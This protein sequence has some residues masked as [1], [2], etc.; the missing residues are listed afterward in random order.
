MSN[1]NEIK[2]ELKER[3][4]LDNLTKSNLSV[5]EYAW[6]K[7]QEQICAKCGRYVFLTIDHIIPKDIL[8]QFGVDVDMEFI[9]ENLQVNCRSCNYFKGNRMDFTIP[10]TKELLIKLISKI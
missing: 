2:K 7:D 9:E 6:L 4:K 1:L 3:K 8:R 5:L 10:K